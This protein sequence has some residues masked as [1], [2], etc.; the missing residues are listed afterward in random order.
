MVLDDHMGSGFGWLANNGAGVLG[1]FEPIGVVSSAITFGHADMEGDGDEDLLV[2]GFI[3][4]FT[5]KL[6]CFLNDG[7][8]S[9]ALPIV[10]EDFGVPS[11]QEGSTS[12]WAVDVDGDGI[13]DVIC[14]YNDGVTRKIFW[15]ANSI[16]EN[17]HVESHAPAFH[18]APNPASQDFLLVC[19]EVIGAEGVIEIVAANGR[20]LRLLHGEG[21][22]EVLVERRDL[23]AGIYLVRVL[24]EGS[25]IGSVRLVVE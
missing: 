18:M 6:V 4:T 3:G 24:R 12:V 1:P 25:Q 5:Y 19:D 20:L 16:A 15:Y 10:L 9:F 7:T 11:I 2:Q 23:P 17:V 22:R 14:S 8:G 21:T 13:L